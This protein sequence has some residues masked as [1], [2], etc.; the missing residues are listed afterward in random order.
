MGSLMGIM[1]FFGCTAYACKSAAAL[2]C[3]AVARA[4]ACT[5][6]AMRAVLSATHAFFQPIRASGM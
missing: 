6:R 4:D 3:L 5:S 1:V 2:A